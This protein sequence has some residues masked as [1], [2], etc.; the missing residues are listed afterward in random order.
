[1]IL[2]LLSKYGGDCQHTHHLNRKATG[3]VWAAAW[4]WGSYG[5]C[6]AMTLKIRGA[7]EFLAKQKNTGAQ[8]LLASR[9]VAHRPVLLSLLMLI[10]G[11][12]GQLPSTA[13]HT[14]CRS[15]NPIP[16]VTWRSVT[17]A[18]EYI[19]SVCP[20]L[21][22]REQ[23][24]LQSEGLQDRLVRI[25]ALASQC[26]ETSWQRLSAQA[27]HANHP[28]DLVMAWITIF[29]KSSPSDSTHGAR[30]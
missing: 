25:W 30:V 8:L 10:W 13:L 5:K 29:L 20:L 2:E 23:I 12:F 3:I 7:L 28:G 19:C 27:V 26:G 9:G 1:M 11:G 22:L 21:V 4:L 16:T 6:H 18:G 24:T 14:Q 17:G 15:P